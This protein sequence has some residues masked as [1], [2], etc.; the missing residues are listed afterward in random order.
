M[1]VGSDYLAH[2]DWL[3][4]GFGRDAHSVGEYFGRQTQGP[5]AIRPV[6]LLVARAESLVFGDEPTGRLLFHVLLH[7]LASVLLGLTLLAAGARAEIARLAAVFFCVWPVHGEILAWYHSG[8]TTLLWVVIALGTLLAHFRGR[9]FLAAALFLLGLLTR[10]NTV[11]L[12][13]IVVL[14]SWQRGDS[15]KVAIKRVSPL[16]GLAAVYVSVR[17]WQI[18]AALQGQPDAFLPVS[19]NP[20]MSAVHVVFKLLLPVHPGVPMATGMLVLVGLAVCALIAVNR[21]QLAGPAV[22]AA[23]W[24]LPFLPLYASGD[25]LFEVT[26]SAYEARWYHLYLPSA[27]LAFLAANTLWSRPRWATLAACALL[28]LQLFNA[29]WWAGLG[30][31]AKT[32]RAQLTELLQLERPLVFE[33]EDDYDALTEVVE[34]QVA[35]IPK[36]APHHTAPVFR[37]KPGENSYIRAAV[38]PFDYPVW[39]QVPRSDLIPESALRVRWIRAEARFVVLE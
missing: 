26:A 25:P 19:S 7:G 12:V 30:E 38:D 39:V 37:K 10:E 32:S 2:D 6:S 21:R 16:I 34:H 17:A 13:P 27:A 33:F 36:M 23:L 35:A 11:M 28:T 8:H 5:P 4:V 20:L 24:C 3:L 18:A 15:L 22:W 9:P 31:Q 14:A 1:V 29:S